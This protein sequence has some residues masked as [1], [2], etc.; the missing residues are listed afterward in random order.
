MKLPVPFEGELI[1]YLNSESH[2]E[3][4]TFNR[5]HYNL[6]SYCQKYYNFRAAFIF[7]N[8]KS[9]NSMETFIR[10]LSVTV[11][12]LIICSA[13]LLLFFF[14][15]S[16]WYERK[17]TKR[18]IE[19]SWSYLVV[20]LTG[21]LCQQ[22]MISTPHLFSGR[23]VMLFMFLFS[24]L[25]YQFYSASLVSHLLMKPSTRIRTVKDILHSNM[26]VGCEDIL[27]NRDYFL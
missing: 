6:M 26:K 2:R 16:Y 3:V 14:K 17:S 5:F 12:I 23:I 1:D 22:G 25:I 19:T 27:Y 11:W 9:K 15:L 13:A 4:N 8:P 24:L 21:A 20:C 7:R 10:P 18:R